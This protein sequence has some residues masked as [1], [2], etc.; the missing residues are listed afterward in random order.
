MKL[1]K[2]IHA[3]KNTPLDGEPYSKNTEHYNIIKAENGVYRVVDNETLIAKVTVSMDEALKIETGDYNCLSSFVYE[4]G[5]KM[6]DLTY[7]VNYHSVFQDEPI[8]TCVANIYHKTD[9]VTNE[10]PYGLFTLRMT[11]EGLRIKTQHYE[12]N[13]T[14]KL[15]KN[16][17]LKSKVKEFFESEADGRKNKSGILLY[18]PPGNGKTTDIMELVELAQELQLRIFLV[19]GKT[20]IE[21]LDMIR[22]AMNG[23]KTVFVLEEMT[24]RLQRGLEDVLTFLDGEKSWTNSVTIATTNYP[25][26]F[27]ANLVD[28]P[29]R[30]ETFIEYGNPENNE[31]VELSKLFGFDEENVKCLFGQNL[32]FDYVSFMLSLAK[33]RGTTVREAKNSEEEKRKRLS[34]TFK[35]KIGL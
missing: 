3:D 10:L 35:G 29:G 30:F 14:V 13:S 21:Y 26:D 2:N 25:E 4:L 15:I 31:I 1:Y 7:N 24:E 16:K 5:F 17:D 6:D 19:D 20:D 28:R 22:P 8:T 11:N 12:N 23:A 34:S 9:K 27:P 32:S 33:K 18:G